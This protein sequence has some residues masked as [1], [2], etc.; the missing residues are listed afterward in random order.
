MYLIERTDEEIDGVLNAAADAADSGTSR[1]PGQTYEDG[2][3]AGIQ[4]ITGS[5]DDNPMDD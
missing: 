3:A 5:A 4:W 2:V 1:W